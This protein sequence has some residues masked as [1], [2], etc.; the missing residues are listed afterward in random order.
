VCVYELGV[1]DVL[2]GKSLLVLRIDG[3][4]CTEAVEGSMPTS[5]R[6]DLVMIGL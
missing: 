4:Q 5:S 6:N 2:E 3:Y 1:L